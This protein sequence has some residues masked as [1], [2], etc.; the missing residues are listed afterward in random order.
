MRWE[1]T[2]LVDAGPARP[3]IERRAVRR[4]HGATVFYEVQA[5]S[6]I[7][8]VPRA[9]GL[10]YRWSVNPYRGCAA[11]CRYCPGRGSHRRLGLDAGAGYGEAIVVRVN[12]A[13]R[14]RAELA[15]PSWPGDPVAVGVAGDCYQGAEE[16]YR[17]M[18]RVVAALRDAGNPFT[19]VTKSPLVLRDVQLLA[20]AARY[21]PVRVMVSV[22]FVDD[23]LRRMV[24]PGA[25]SPQKRLEV[26]AALNEAGVP[27]GVLLAP[28]LPCLTDSFDQLRAAVRR[29]AEAGAVEVTPVV[30]TLPPGAREW[31]LAWLAEEHPGLVRRYGELYASGPLAAAGYRERITA[32]V[33]RLA[34]VYGVGR[35]ARRWRRR[36]SPARQLALL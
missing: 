4:S 12:A 20:D 13:R 31:Y 18:P 15:R 7:E 3:R 26:C 14:L 5:R 1:A 17:L 16:I 30:L 19:V 8:A 22:G 6:V 10:P 11:A 2:S 9:T 27:C 33:A 32:E 25:V 35:S 34:E 29:A 23:R 24:E 21:V 28:V 36:R